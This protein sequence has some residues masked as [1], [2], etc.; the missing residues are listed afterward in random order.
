[1]QP[2][3]FYLYDR[4]YINPTCGIP[5]RSDAG[6]DQAGIVNAVRASAHGPPWLLYGVSY[7]TIGGTKVDRQWFRESDI[8]RIR[9]ED[10]PHRQ[11]VSDDLLRPYVGSTIL[12]QDDKVDLPWFV[13]G[14]HEVFTDVFASGH[15]VPISSVM[16]SIIRAKP[17]QTKNATWDSQTVLLDDLIMEPSVAVGNKSFAGK[18]ACTNRRKELATQFVLALA[19]KDKNNR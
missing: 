9:S 1:M 13:V 17:G 4:V 5:P 8:E 3:E 15:C 18:V 16:C 12:L 6:S 7:F 11:A 19:E 2:H 14:L 10:S